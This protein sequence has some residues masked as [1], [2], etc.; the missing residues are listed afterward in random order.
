MGVAKRGGQMLQMT[1]G[2][3]HCSEDCFLRE[4]CSLA[5]L[6]S[7]VQW[8][9]GLQEIGKINV[10]VFVVEGRFPVGHRC[11]IGLSF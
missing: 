1:K 11:I 5:E 2:E 4:L 7:D 10:K 6:H 8:S 9:R 3:N